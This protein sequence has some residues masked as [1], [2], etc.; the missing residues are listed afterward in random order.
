MFEFEPVPCREIKATSHTNPA[1]HV[2]WPCR[3]Y[4]NEIKR[5]NVCIRLLYKKGSPVGAFWL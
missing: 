2:L 5:E 4:G 3:D 1:G